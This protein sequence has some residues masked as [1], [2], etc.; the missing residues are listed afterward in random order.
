MSGFVSSPPAAPSSDEGRLDHDGWYPG[1]DLALLRDTVRVPTQVTTARL[2]AAAI[3]AMITVAGELASWRAGQAATDL[4]G[5]AEDEVAGKSRLEALYERAV[6]SFAA[7]DLAETHSDVTATGDGKDRAAARVLTAE[8]H[9]RNGTH[10]IRDI[11]GVTR[12]AVEL[13]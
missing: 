7:A 8:E 1:V 4:A 2:T 5:V 11:L 10:A 12:T 9:R 3:A 13:I 6:Y